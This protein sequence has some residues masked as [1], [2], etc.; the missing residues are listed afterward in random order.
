MGKRILTILIIV[1]FAVCNVSGVFS[2]GINNADRDET[3]YAM[4]KNDGSVDYLKTVSRLQGADNSAEYKYENIDIKELPVIL[5]LNYFLDGTEVTADKLVG[6]SGEIKVQI[7]VRQN[8]S[9]SVDLKDRFMTQ[10]QM[11][12][13]LEHA[14]IKK[15]NGTSSVI[16]GSTE[17]LSYVVLPGEKAD[18]EL[19]MD[20]RDFQMDSVQIVLVDYASDLSSQFGGFSDGVHT[21]SEKAGEMVDG[22]MELK[23]GMDKLSNGMGDLD[24]AVATLGNGA[25]SLVKGMK[26]YS[27]GL[28][29]YQKGLDSTASGIDSSYKGLQQ[30]NAGGALLL[31]GYEDL[32]G[33]V[34][35][36]SG[37]H[38]ELVKLAKK[39][40]SSNNPEIQALC[41]GVIAEA[42]GM[43]Q[44]AAGIAQANQ[45]LGAYTA[46]VGKIEN[47]MGELNKG[48]SALSTGFGQLRAGFAGLQSGLSRMTSGLGELKKG[49]SS[50]LTSVKEIPQ[51]VQK[52]ADGQSQFKDGI[53]E[54][55]AEINKNISP[56]T[57]TEA[58]SFT[59]G[60]TKINSL[61]FVMKTPELKK[62]ESKVDS[63]VTDDKKKSLIERIWDRI[64]GLF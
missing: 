24:G 37:N 21:M 47:G 55:E 6:S 16:T 3:V 35:Q 11:P 61:Q 36:L 62:S 49:T 50:L 25:S 52:L 57:K 8:A 19:I 17:T 27:K 20:A 2:E 29:Q 30:A 60:K 9:C 38:N 26:D 10:I 33:T 46:G 32:Y 4:L 43:K 18:F 22:T 64:I 39:L 42:E 40:Q 54:M 31:K 28:E 53:D 13:N 7:G 44:I 23:T 34:E 41:Q 15:F 14:I 5:D 45:G 59:D 12:I 58:V 51:S 1:F 63:V 56:K 48:V